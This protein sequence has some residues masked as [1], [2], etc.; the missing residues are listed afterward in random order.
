[1][2][3]DYR[4]KAACCALFGLTAAL[5]S[6]G[7]RRGEIAKQSTQAIVRSSPTYSKTLLRSQP[8]KVTRTNVS[9]AELK[10]AKVKGAKGLTQVHFV[11]ENTG[12]AADRKLV[13]RTIDG[14]RNWQ[15]LDPKIPSET[16]IS[17]V[18]FINNRLGW[19]SIIKAFHVEPF[20]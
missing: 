1:M 3:K 17:S 7:V 20:G 8:A 18:F 5:S 6:C 15:K 14:G 4:V 12:W 16:S 19:L 9:L 11:D 2:I 10:V 13:F